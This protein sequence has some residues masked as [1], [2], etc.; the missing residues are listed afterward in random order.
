MKVLPRLEKKT[1]KM[2]ID[3]LYYLIEIYSNLNRYKDIKIEADEILRF[4]PKAQDAHYC[5]GIY[6]YVYEHNRSKSYQYLKKTIDLKPDSDAAHRAEY[7]IDYIRANPD[8]RVVPDF[9]F[10]DRD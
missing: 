5:L 2:Y 7:A 9:S 8:S 10:I 6:Y 1:K 3:C 4:K